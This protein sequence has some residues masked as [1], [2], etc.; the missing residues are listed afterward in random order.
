MKTKLSFLGRGFLIAV[1]LVISVPT[2]TI[3]ALTD[4]LLDKYAANNIMFYDPEDCENDG[5][6]GAI[7][8]GTAVVSGSTAAEKIWSGLKS[9]GLSDEITAGIM[10]NMA[11]EGNMNPAQHEGSQYASYWPM[12]L[13]S[14]ANENIAYGLGLIQWS[15]ERRVNMYNYVKEKSPGLTKYFDNPD[16][17]SKN[18]GS[19]YGC[20]GDCFI[21]KAESENEANALYSLELTYLLYEL[22]NNVTGVD[23]S[24]LFEQTTVLGATE[25]FLREVERPAVL[26]LSPRLSS[27]QEYYDQ[28]HGQTSFGSG[29]TGGTATSTVD[30]TKVTIIG[31]SITVGAESTL[32]SELAGAD[33][34]A[35][36]SKRFSGTVSDN[37]TGTEILEEL[38]TSGQ[39]REVLVFALGTNQDWLTQA[40]IDKVL[41]L[42]SS[43]S[44]IVFVT[45]HTSTNN[46]D[47]NNTL[48][49]QAAAD[50]PSKVVVADWQ[51]IVRGNE[52]QYLS[53]G[54]HPNAEGNTKFVEVIKTAI[55][56]A[57]VG[58]SVDE[59]CDPADG[60]NGSEATYTAQKYQLSEGQIKGLLAMVKHENGG[61]LNGV[62]LEASL[63]A[64]LYEQKRPDEA[65]TADGLVNYVRTG[66]WFATAD[67]YDENYSDY[68]QTEF[69]AVKDIW[70][71]GNRTI[72]AE[73]VE[74]DSIGDIESI[75]LD[76][77][78]VDK[79]DKNNY[80]QGKTVINNQMGST[81]IFYT[82][83]NPDGT[84]ISSSS[85]NG[86]TGDP[87]GYF[88][89][90]PPNG[91]AVT[92]AS[93]SACCDRSGSGN[94][95]YKT[96]DGIKYAFPL[97]DATQANY[98]SPATFGSG[99]SVLSNLPCNNLAAG[100]CHH[101]YHAVDMGL[102]MEM[103]TGKDPTA[104][105]YGG[106][107]GYSN[108]YYNSAGAQ[109]VA[110]TSG[111]IEYVSPYTNG[112]DESWWD[113][114]GQIGLTGDDGNY[115]WLGHLDL[116]SASVSDGDHVEAGDNLAK[117]GAPQC[118]QG[119]QSH[120]HIDTANGALATGKTTA[121]IVELMD[122][123]WAELPT[124]D[125]TSTTVD[126]CEESGLKTGGMTMEEAEEFMETYKAEV[127]KYKGKTDYSMTTK[128]GETRSWS[129]S[130]TADG[131]EGVLKNC[132]SFTKWFV[133]NYVNIPSGYEI[134]GNGGDVVDNMGASGNFKTGTEP[135]P[136][137]VFS[138]KNDSY[139]H[140]GIVLGVN[141]DGTFIVG[142]SSCS[143]HW[144]SDWIGHAAQYSL[145]SHNWEFAYTDGMIDF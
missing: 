78:T 108:M 135:R 138:W 142:E 26:N 92:G 145:S 62:K 40:D 65:H 95:T 93:S 51:A 64:N 53:D 128:N 21:S 19:I 49:K 8:G 48:F 104:D 17:Y 118:A 39:L 133:Y 35:Q 96:I 111:T 34:H 123:L 24:G 89:N 67:D 132:V 44:K 42:A 3:Y 75:T 11:H 80:V 122:E 23:Y 85:G 70:L 32:N 102:M 99:E 114:C 59:C 82:W 120:L 125:T 121:W 28:F 79:M 91:N 71:N 126:S 20:D 119:T 45:N 116:E 74:H 41:E 18:N 33:I 54:T 134:S 144:D 66:G 52:S 136:Y 30:G 98:L 9:M 22:Q 130:C 13:S 129:N 47:T 115:Y 37:K 31:D 38:S 56:G 81:Y 143:A 88:Q 141:D 107:A 15:Y 55:G 113:K 117:I 109:V 69:E 84:T 127:L 101:G 58:T 137:A 46:Y 2:Q 90:N 94:V 6:S 25:Y 57:V 63:M 12:D 112:V 1:A 97:A 5:S 124:D 29:S 7:V 100:A 16:T 14:E 83:A 106:E 10:G 140:T 87:F 36:V 43:A 103:V 110:I 86:G 76:G 60:S 72:P 50:N 77:Q 4:E 105:D 139:G 27:A 68:S 61:T 73:I 131:I